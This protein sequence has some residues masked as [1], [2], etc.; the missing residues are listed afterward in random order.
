MSNIKNFISYDEMQKILNEIDTSKQ[1]KLEYQ[2]YLK[3]LIERNSENYR[4]ALMEATTACE[5]CATQE[6]QKRCNELGIDGRG[7]CNTYYRSLGDRFALLKQLGIA[8]A[9]QDPNK[10]IVKP[11]NDLFHNRTITPTA[12]ECH[13]VLKAVRKYLN[14]YIPEM[15]E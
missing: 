5:L 14:A 12:G 13:D 10:E 2:L 7:L 3:S 8:W 6:I 1:L 15:Y 4:Y 9:T 11:R